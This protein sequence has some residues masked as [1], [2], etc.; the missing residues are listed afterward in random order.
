M[1]R[2]TQEELG[3]LFALDLLK[4]RERAVFAGA[5]RDD[6][7][8]RAFTDELCETAALLAC[9]EG[10]QSPT[11]GLKQRLQD[12]IDRE[13]AP[14]APPPRFPRFLPLLGWAAAA[15]FAGLALWLGQLY[16]AARQENDLLA[17][18]QSLTDTALRSAQY[19]IEAEQIIH[20]H[21]LQEARRQLARLDEQPLALADLRI[22]TCKAL[23]DHAPQ[24]VALTVWHQNGQSGLFV[25][26][27][28]PTLPPD[29]DY[30][31]WIF[32]P[33][34]PAPLNAGVF[35]VN[36]ATGR[37]EFLFQSTRPIGPATRFA[38]SLEHKGGAPQAEG[39]LVL[40]S[41]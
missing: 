11:P 31:L 4:D 39:P 23:T 2:E 17:R 10:E 29:R 16:Y 13:P 34:H 20:R 8:L 26:D 18:A 35:Q 19:R 30:Q 28:L 37:A 6:P 32:D 5:M 15:C 36:P 3:A 22:T 14:G 1:N 24:A 38:V 7:R 40:A 27:H 33:Q 12:R 9:C 21:E 41:D 25:T